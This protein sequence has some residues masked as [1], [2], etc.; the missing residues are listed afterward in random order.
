MVLLELLIN[1]MTLLW[2]NNASLPARLSHLT[3][4]LDL[5]EKGPESYISHY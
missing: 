5:S 1:L 3:D 2:N 4:S